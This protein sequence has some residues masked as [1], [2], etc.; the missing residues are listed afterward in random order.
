MKSRLLAGLVALSLAAP[1]FAQS[2]TSPS[3]LGKRYVEG[4][5][6]YTNYNHYP[7]DF[8]FGATVNTPLCASFDV[9]STFFH[10]RQEGDASHHYEMLDAHLAAHRDLGPVRA[11]ARATLGYEWWSVEN[12]TW[13]RLD[14]GA[15][16]ALT[17]RLL[18]SAHVS[19]Q[20]FFSSDVLEGRF[21]VTSKAT[22]WVTSSVAVSLSGAYIE[23]GDLATRLGLA[24]VF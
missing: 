7:A 17:E 23:T 10:S 14:A 2:A 12:L 24:F 18:I 4:F 19:W 6:S 15:E 3:L 1:A 5:A 20:D 16:R 13:Y 8:G 22:F 11:F 21:S 9:G